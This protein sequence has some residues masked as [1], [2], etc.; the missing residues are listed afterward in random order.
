MTGKKILKILGIELKNMFFR[1][2]KNRVLLPESG[3]RKCIF[4]LGTTSHNNLGDHAISLAEILFIQKYINE[5]KLIEVLDRDV[6]RYLPKIKKRIQKEDLVFLHGGGNMG[7]DYYSHEMI[8]RKVVKA[9]PKQKIV[10]FPQT[11]DYGNSFTGKV[12]RGLTKKTFNRHKHLCIATREEHSFLLS[13]KYFPNALNVLTPDIVLSLYPLTIDETKKNDFLV[14]LR[15]DKEKQLKKTTE[16]KI[17][18]LLKSKG[19]CVEADMIADEG[20]P[21]DNRQNILK[22]RWNMFAES[23]VVVTDRLHGMIFSFLTG[24]DCIVFSNYNHKVRG[25][26]E[27]LKDC[28]Y[29]HYMNMEKY[30]TKEFETLIDQCRARTKKHPYDDGRLT[31]GFIPILEFVRNDRDESE[32]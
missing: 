25:T 17:R 27:W 10:I 24:T 19:T 4:L 13:K 31:D 3:N 16:D 22:D 9:L 21:I 29:I 30:S 32:K 2:V 14:C 20:V 12:V 26:Y 11:I 15:S 6:C 7:I 23:R 28:G 5:Y 8:R 1:G 18:A